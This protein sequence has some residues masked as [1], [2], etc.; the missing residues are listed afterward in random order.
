[1]PADI[2]E[3]FKIHFKNHEIQPSL[4]KYAIHHKGRDSYFAYRTILSLDGNPK[5]QSI[6]SACQR[7]H[8][9]NLIGQTPVRAKEPCRI[10][11]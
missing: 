6:A 5:A 4:D 11:L 10:L 7:L 1:M 2:M 8:I 3:I 9:N